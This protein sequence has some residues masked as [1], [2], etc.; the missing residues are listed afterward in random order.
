[1]LQRVRLQNQDSSLQSPQLQNSQL[2]KRNSQSP[3]QIAKTFGTPIWTAEYALRFLEKVLND[4]RN[5]NK[6]RTH[7]SHYHQH[8]H[9]HHHKRSHNAKILKGNYI[10]IES[11][12]SKNY[13]P[14]YREFKSWPKIHLSIGNN[15]SPFDSE[16]KE[17][18]RKNNRNTNT[19][20]TAATVNKANN[21]QMGITK[22]IVATGGNTNHENKKEENSDKQCGYCEICRVEYDVLKQHLKSDEHLNFVKNDDNFISL[23]KLIKDSSNVDK[24][25]NLKQESCHVLITRTSFTRSQAIRETNE[26][27]S[28][29]K[30][31][32]TKKKNN[33]VINTN[34]CND[35]DGGGGDKK[36]K[37]NNES[38]QRRINNE[39][40]NNLPKLPDKPRKSGIERELN[41]LLQTGVFTEDE[42]RRSRRESSRRINYAEP[43][44]DDD[45]NSE[46]TIIF[47]YLID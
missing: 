24:F 47:H 3:V 6:E 18:T 45:E 36:D 44:E 40:V 19:T 17:M 22:S 35:D 43:K 14:V 1:M 27:K 13:R 30:S 38:K 4:T 34:E 41:D 16:N 15:S 39:R 37:K 7:N 28:G 46:G 8:N 20:T 23:D 21:H 11:L 12:N 33:S 26:T 32:D 25:L 5:F 42:T 9:H 29:E 10:K 31:K 2:F